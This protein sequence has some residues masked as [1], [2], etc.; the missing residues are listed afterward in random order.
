MRT[1]LTGPLTLYTDIISGLDTNDGLT[2]GTALQSINTAI[3]I[4]VDQYDLAGNYIT[5][6]NATGQYLTTGIQLLNGCVGRGG[7][8]VDFGGS[9]LYVTNNQAIANFGGGCSFFAI[10]N[11][12]VGTAT[13][14]Y[15]VIAQVPGYIFIGPNV[16]LIGA[17]SAGIVASGPGAYVQIGT[18]LQIS[19]YMP[20]AWLAA[21]TGQ[22]VGT[23]APS[24]VT[25]TGTPH[26]G[27][28]ASASTCGIIQPFNFSFVG[29]CVGSKYSV[30]LNGVINTGGLTLPGSIAGTKVTGGQYS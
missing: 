2:P 25:L 15:A 27:S 13:S 5:V 10:Q 30:S 7:I 4:A 20:H 6:Q 28:F 24:V 14:G 29:A 9:T 19:G 17:A 12:N 8:A 26:F 1:I 21:D 23:D 18:S 3:Q 16:N 11:V 22:I